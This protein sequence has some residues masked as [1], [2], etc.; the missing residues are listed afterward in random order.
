MRKS[1]KFP[2]AGLTDWIEFC[3]LLVVDP[4]F[5]ASHDRRKAYYEYRLGKQYA[6]PFC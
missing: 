3:W 2:P 4:S 5:Q 6:M 1:G